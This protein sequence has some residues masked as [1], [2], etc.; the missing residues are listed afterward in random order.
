MSLL[1]V[2]K[3]SV[4]YH[5]RGGEIQAD[6][7]ITFNV[8][9]GEILGVI[10]ESGAGKSTIGN[11]ILQLVTVAGEVSC[12]HI[13][14]DQED[15][16]KFD[17]QKMSGVRGRRIAM[18]FQDPSTSLNP[19]FSIERQLVDAIMLHQKLN[20]SEAK[21]LALQYLVRV[22]IPHPIKTL[23]SYPHQLSGGMQKKRSMLAPQHLYLATEK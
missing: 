1:D 19:V 8:N 13:M 14:L 4:V 5:S 6:E 15:I 23:K 17:D 22:D 21:K 11:A 7:D 20:K 9:A 16:S 3:L 18:I 12:D 2:K 10:G